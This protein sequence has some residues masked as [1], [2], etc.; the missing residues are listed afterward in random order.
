MPWR[1]FERYGLTTWPE[2]LA[3]FA[4]HWPTHEQG[5]SVQA[6]RELQAGKPPSAR[7]GGTSSEFR[8]TERWTSSAKSVFQFDMQGSVAKSSHAG[9]PW[10][11]WLRE[12]IGERLHLWPFDG[13]EPHPDKCVLAEVYPSLFRNRYPRDNRTVDQQDAFACAQWM[14]DMSRRGRLA[15]YFACPPLDEKEH[16]VVQC[17]G[18]VLGVR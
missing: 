18:W 11:K 15:D 1:Y 12:E 2:F 13:W 14:A 6:I 3:D 17:E 9:I 8:I 10:L 16:A 4:D 7:R 5:V